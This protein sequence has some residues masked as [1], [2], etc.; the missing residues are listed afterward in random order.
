MEGKFERIKNNV[1]SLASRFVKCY[2]GYLLV[3]FIVFLIGFLTGIFTC[4]SYVE[5]LTCENLINTY[6]YS[7]LQNEMTFFSFFLTLSI[8]F[9]LMCAFTIFLVRNKFMIAINV[10]LLFLLSYI[11]GFDLCIVIMCLGLSG[12]IFGVLF[13]CL[14]WLVIFIFYMCIMSIFCKKVISKERCVETFKS[15]FLSA[16][17]FIL[18]SL[19]VLFV[20]CLLFSIIHIFVIVD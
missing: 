19:I 16:L 3:F 7:F 11:F 15:M 6:L 1:M 13:Y 4:S 8:F 10:I 14:F 2:K 12:I 9:I 17:Y 20:S 5:D 18:L